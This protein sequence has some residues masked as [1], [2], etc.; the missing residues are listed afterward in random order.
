MNYMSPNQSPGTMSNGTRRANNMPM[1]M[2]GAV[3]VAFML[4]MAMVAMDRAEQQNHKAEEMP[5]IAGNSDTAA[6]EIVGDRTGGLVAPAKPPKPEPD[7]SANA[8]IKTGDNNK[9]AAAAATAPRPQPVDEEAMRIRQVKMQM[10]NEAIR[11]KTTI[12]GAAARSSGSPPPPTAADAT[13]TKGRLAEIRRMMAA[14]QPDS[15]DPTEAY[16]QRLAQ[17][18]AAGLMGG[19]E[20][21]S[22]GQQSGAMAARA[23]SDRWELGQE[24]QAPRSPFELRAGSVLPATLI[25]G[26]NSDL[27]GQIMAQ[28]AQDV[29]D[30]P[31]GKHLLIPQGSRLVGTY[32]SGVAYGQERVLV[33]WTRIVCPD[34]KALDI[35]SMPG[36]DGGGYAG[37]ED[38]VNHHYVR[39]F[40]SAILMSAVTA[41]VTYSQRQSDGGDSDRTDASS[42][43]SEALGQQLGQATAQLLAKNLSIAPTIEIRP[44]YRFNVIVTKDLTFSK[45]YQSFD[46]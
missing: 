12:R 14:N 18:R 5:V 29:F 33:A 9:P 37:F 36:A 38:K 20:P 34:G 15:T 22:G 7:P 31:T 43:L 42:V 21:A 24:I 6:R 11:S 45:P 39:F 19:A 32:N 46:Y 41:G 25:S 27:P 1:Y 17:I 40:A 4:I 13:D 10:L 23:P 44:G 35:G 3:L 28:V 26:I 8:R 16:K 2:L 30:T